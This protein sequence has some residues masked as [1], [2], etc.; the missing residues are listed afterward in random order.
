[1]SASGD[2]TL[3]VYGPLGLDDLVYQS[4]GG[5]RL[6]L[7]TDAQSSVVTAMDAA[8]HVLERYLYADY[9]GRSVATGPAGAFEEGRAS[10]LGVEQGFTGAWLDAE[11][12]LYWLRTRP[13]DPRM[14]RFLRRDPAGIWAD[15]MGLG[16]GYQYAANDPATLVDPMGLMAM[17]TTLPD[18]GPEGIC[19]LCDDPVDVPAATPAE[20]EETGTREKAAEIVE[21]YK[22]AILAPL[23]EASAGYTRLGAL[24]GV[25]SSDP[26]VTE[27]RAQALDRSASQARE[28]ALD[29][30]RNSSTQQA[31]RF[32]AVYLLVQAAMIAEPS[33]SGEVTATARATSTSSRLGLASKARQALGAAS[34]RLG[35]FFRRADADAAGGTPTDRLKAHLTD[36]DL[37][38]AR[39]EAAGEVVARRSDGTPFN[40][41]QEV[42]DAQ[43]GLLN[44]IQRINGQLGRPNL[45]EAE[46]HALQGELSEAS[47]LLDHSEGYLPR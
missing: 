19:V 35:S 6:T 39:R 42:R 12:G 32:L 14:G 7:L 30:A 44:R 2:V 16:N 25:G 23:Y 11:V 31:M 13:M 38:A 41:V 10:A 47:R 17:P 4:R 37:D 22:G 26:A 5:Q 46:R 29:A 9:G 33:P 20:V 15:A 34:D 3:R 28:K 21:G 24:L 27:A 45:P 43:Q 36:R 40:H 8:G 18:F 1:M